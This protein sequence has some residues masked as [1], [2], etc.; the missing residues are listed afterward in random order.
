M[1]NEVVLYS[2]SVASSVLVEKNSDRARFLLTAAKVTFREVDLSVQ[3]AGLSH[4]E[5]IHPFTVSFRQG[6][7]DRKLNS[8]KPSHYPTDLLQRQVLRDLPA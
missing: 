8:F 1:S 4:V 6:V 2:S 7:H 3:E 5:T